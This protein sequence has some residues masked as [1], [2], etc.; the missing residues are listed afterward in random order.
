[1]GA[2]QNPNI[3]FCQ[4]ETLE[5]AYAHTKV[6]IT[7]DNMIGTIFAIESENYQPTLNLV[8]KTKDPT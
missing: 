6:R 3:L 2:D 5:L 4:L 7:D 8:A 1:M